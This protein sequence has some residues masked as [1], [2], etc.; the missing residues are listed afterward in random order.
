MTTR[1]ARGRSAFTLIELLVVVAII[2]LLLSILLP[3]L[4]G[5]K[6]V[7]RRVVCGSNLRQFGIGMRSYSLE[8]N[9]W[10]VGAPNGSGFAAFDPTTSQ[11]DYPRK[12]TTIYDWSNP[13][14][15]YI[16]V[17]DLARNRGVRMFNSRLGVNK[18]PDS[19]QTMIIFGSRPGD[20]PSNGTADV[21]PSV[22]YLTNWKLLMAGNSYQ[23]VLQGFAGTA[24]VNWLTYSSGWETALPPKFL[25]RTT[26]IGQNARKIFLMDGARFVTDQDVY[27]YDPRVG[28]YLGAGS[29]SSSGA[30]YRASQEYGENRR[31]RPLSLRHGLSENALAANALFF[32][33]HVETL[34]EKRTHYLPFHAPTGSTVTSVT[35]LWPPAD[36]GGFGLGDTVPD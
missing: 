4:A 12:P 15:R 35:G 34:A 33:G 14:A 17:N 13:M 24:Q 11:D 31:A 32:D 29:Y 28:N 1:I 26:M 8:E 36:N 19:N 22:S 16:G 21:Q 25:P 27:D 2:A 6:K 18:C 9:D 3:S 23:N 30:Q 20:F 5:A 10:I 7:A